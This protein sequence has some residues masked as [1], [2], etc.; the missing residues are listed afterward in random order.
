MGIGTQREHVSLCV[1]V[2]C[3]RDA[4]VGTAVG[5][6]GGRGAGAGAVDDAV[7]DGARAREARL[8]AVCGD[9]PHRARR[10]HCAETRARRAALHPRVRADEHDRERAVGRAQQR[11][12]R[13]HE[14]VLR[15]ALGRRARRG[16]LR[17]RRL[18]APRC[19][20]RLP[21]HHAHNHTRVTFPFHRSLQSS[22]QVGQVGLTKRTM[23]MTVLVVSLFKKWRV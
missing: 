3:E 5:C 7:R 11:V 21:V 10:E 23:T 4:L 9:G 2:G 19:G 8:G 16:P 13:G 6:R 15:R 17:R 18:G 20:P 14:E 12:E 1:C 22:M